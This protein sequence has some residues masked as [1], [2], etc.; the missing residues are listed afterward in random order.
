MALT[1]VIIS[2]LRYSVL[3]QSSLFSSF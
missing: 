1:V 3:L 2:Y